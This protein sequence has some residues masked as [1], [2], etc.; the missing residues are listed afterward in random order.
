MAVNAFTVDLEDRSFWG[1]CGWLI[2]SCFIRLPCFDTC[3]R[4][5]LSSI[6]YAWFFQCWQT[7]RLFVLFLLNLNECWETQNFLDPL[8]PALHLLNLLNILKKTHVDLLGSVS[9]L[10]RSHLNVTSLFSQTQDFIKKVLLSLL[11]DSRLRFWFLMNRIYCTFSKAL[12]FTDLLHY[13]LS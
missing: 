8:V 7:N 9:H 11:D 4:I 6:A 12:W 5:E 10:T 3:I 13:L 1:V 2:E